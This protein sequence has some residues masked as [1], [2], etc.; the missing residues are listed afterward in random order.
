MT[1]IVRTVKVVSVVLAPS[2][3]HIIIDFDI[4]ANVVLAWSNIKDLS[5]RKAH[6]PQVGPY[7]SQSEASTGRLLFCACLEIAAKFKVTKPGSPSKVEKASFLNN[8]PVSQPLSLTS[9]RRPCMERGRETRVGL[10]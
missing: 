5:N 7:V 3:Q 1:V 4:I 6:C 8:V 2:G 9:W 10:M